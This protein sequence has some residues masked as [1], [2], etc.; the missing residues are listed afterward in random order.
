LSL[1][2]EF[3]DKYKYI[4]MY[5]LSSKFFIFEEIKM[6]YIKK[7]DVNSSVQDVPTRTS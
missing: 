2:F 1:K 5:S 3:E 6:G 4:C 7:D